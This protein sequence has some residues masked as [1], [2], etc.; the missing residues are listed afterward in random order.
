MEKV[1]SLWPLRLGNPALK[2]ASQVTGGQ[3]QIPHHDP[4][5]PEKQ[6]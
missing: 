4:V 3:A 1:T 5:L 6:T 2:A